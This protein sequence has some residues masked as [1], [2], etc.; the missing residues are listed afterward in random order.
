MASVRY[1]SILVEQALSREY[2]SE[3]D[4]VLKGMA[5]LNDIK[6]LIREFEKVFAKYI[7]VKEAVAVNS[8]S[9]ALKM[10]LLAA[11]V[12]RG[13][14]VIVPN[15]TYQAVAL[16]VCYCG[17]KPVAVDAMKE[18]LEINPELIEKAIS[19]KT[20]AL[21]AA[22]MFGRPCQMDR[23][24]MICQKK[25]IILIEDVCQAESSRYKGQMLGSFGDMAVFSFSYYKPLSSCGGGGGMV[26]CS[27]NKSKRIRRWMQD[28]QD[29][30]ELLKTGQRFAPMALM[31][32]IA[33]RVKFFHLKEIIKSR[34]Q[35]KALY[36]KKLGGIKG[37]TIFKDQAQTES[38]AQ[39]FVICAQSRDLLFDQLIKQ[40]VMAQKA[41]L[42][43][44]R[45]AALKGIKKKF[46][47]SEWYA[48][49]ALHLPL[50]S[51]MSQDKIEH[52]VACCQSFL[53]SQNL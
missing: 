19:K 28:W 52:V 2:A 31:D 42:P 23:I 38:V 16:A 51:F 32:L 7:G 46:P 21:I 25:N 44:H 3:L 35:A 30:G 24:K 29:D 47:V 49:T 12:G 11:D 20:K 13:D 15:L 22:H 26:V 48:D 39:N 40:G 4:T 53:R 17:A 41:Y 6:P 1:E 43:L 14:E 45:M 50:H 34:Y 9:D 5:G 10:A 33:L 37:L 27:E 8:G 18:D 36:E